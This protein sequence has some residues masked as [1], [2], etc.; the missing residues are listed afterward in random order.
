M[1]FIR[2]NGI[3]YWPTPAESPDLN[4]IEML[5]HEL[6]NFLATVIKPRNKEELVEGI[7]LFW[8]RRVTPEKCQRYIGHLQ[9][10]LP[11]VI[12]REGR[13]SGHWSGHAVAHKTTTAPLGATKWK[14]SHGQWNH[15]QL[16]YG[17]KNNIPFIKVHVASLWQHSTELFT[18]FV[19]LWIH[20]NRGMITWT[21]LSH[22][23]KAKSQYSAKLQNTQPQL[24]D[25]KCLLP[26]SRSQ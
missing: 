6:K 7:R 14:K 2:D 23:F 1:T 12:R 18:I 20:F 15:A 16:S 21:Y 26:W 5:W 8:S 22:D 4:P 24:R 25:I 17:C 9:K 3:N 11:E 10:V 13:A 19:S